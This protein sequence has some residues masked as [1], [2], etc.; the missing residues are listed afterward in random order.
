MDCMKKKILLHV[1]CGPCS[2]HCI[3]VLK[4]EYDVTLYF[5]GSNIFPQEEYEKRRAQARKVAMHHGLE[6]IEEEYDHHA[7]RKF[8]QGLESE[9]EG[10]KRC[11]VCFRFNL[12]KVA[13]YA[14]T[15]SFDLFT[16][17]LTVSPHK[18]A[19]VI[20]AIGESLG[21]FVPIDFKKKDGFRR[22][23]Q[24]SREQGLYRQNYCGCEH[25]MSQSSLSK[26]MASPRE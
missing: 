4:Q 17:T 26:S 8:I 15:H 25:S 10:G 3:E 22:S 13:S 7:W 12:A 18:D 11:E 19:R 14:K 21:N 1:C 9:P 20:F 16:T 6:M 5:A 23:C 24:L 2:T